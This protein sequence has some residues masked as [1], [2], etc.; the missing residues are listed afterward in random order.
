LANLDGVVITVRDLE[1][2]THFYQTVLGMPLRRA[3]SSRAT[4]DFGRQYLTLTVAGT[5]QGRQPATPIPGSQHLRLVSDLPMV[6]VIT[7]LLRLNVAIEDTPQTQH[8]NGEQFETLSFRD[9]DGNLIEIL[10]PAPE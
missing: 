7:H 3:G 1:R 9:P 2:S 8:T 6:D 10:G 5:H 4:L